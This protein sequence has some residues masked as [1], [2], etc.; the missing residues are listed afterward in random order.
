MKSD[1]KWPL[2]LFALLIPLLP[3]VSVFADV[4]QLG[5]GW[6]F[7][8]PLFVFG[9]VPAL[10]LLVGDD[11]G[12]LSPATL[13]ALV[14]SGYHRR[15][16]DLYIP[17]QIVAF[18]TCAWF[19]GQSNGLGE[20]VGIIFSAGIVGGVAIN[21]AHELGH[22]KGDAAKRLSLL[23][24]AQSGYG[25]FYVEHNRGHHRHVATP[26][27]PASARFGES[28]WRFLPRTVTGSFASAVRLERDRLNRRN[29]G[30]VSA[31]N[32]ILQGALLTAILW[33]GAVALAG[34]SVWP[35]LLAQAVIGIFLLEDVNYLEH[36]GLRRQKLESGR[37]EACRPE[38]S[39]NSDHRVSNM[40]LY[41]L[42]RHSDHHANP[43]REYQ[44][45]RSFDDAPGLPTGYSGM[46]LLSTVPW[47]W[48]KV[49]DPRVLAHYQEDRSLLNVG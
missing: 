4:M 33:L 1:P 32:H 48:R 37:Y 19:Y 45:L 49:M 47:L 21:A 17:L 16:V 14:G 38:H 6:W 18:A 13:D 5:W 34:F 11:S 22:K 3:F 12:N 39:W 46:L 42:Q 7:F 24:L 15:L 20:K 43:T 8:T 40:F 31:H 36:Y 44:V 2:W 30:F 35:F 41:Q 29:L 23:A 26:E 25:H 9:F 28:L 27:D 10:D